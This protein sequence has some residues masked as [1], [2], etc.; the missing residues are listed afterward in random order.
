MKI[1]QHQ[2]SLIYNDEYD[3]YDNQNLNPRSSNEGAHSK[4]SSQRQ[5][6]FNI[7]SNDIKLQSNSDF[8]PLQASQ[9]Q[10]ITPSQN[11]NTSKKLQ[12]KNSSS[13]DLGKMAPA[14]Q[15][16]FSIDSTTNIKQLV[17][18][19]EKSKQNL[20]DK[21]Q[22]LQYRQTELKQII[23]QQRELIVLEFQESKRQE[24]EIQLQKNKARQNI[25]E[26]ESIR[27]LVNE[28]KKLLRKHQQNV[29]EQIESFTIMKNDTIKTIDLKSNKVLSE[30][31]QLN[32]QLNQENERINYLTQRINESNTQINEMRGV[33]HSKAMARSVSQNLI[34]QSMDQLKNLMRQ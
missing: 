2:D 28:Q 14:D 26:V 32:Q 20:L 25:K 6:G 30:C 34:R 16:S 5:K 17:K 7:S 23:S 12:L 22:K 15:L 8:S 4:K 18:E 3:Y 11:L 13:K 10:N 29:E 27:S 19:F 1:E 21:K 9:N 31:Y 24:N 33:L